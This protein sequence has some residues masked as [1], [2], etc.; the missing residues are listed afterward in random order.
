MNRKQACITWSIIAVLAIAT[1][2]VFGDAG[3]ASG[4]PAGG[5][6]GDFL[7]RTPGATFVI[8]LIIWGITNNRRNNPK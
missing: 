7:R 6:L 8:A 3:Y 5:D 1:Q 4:I 2:S